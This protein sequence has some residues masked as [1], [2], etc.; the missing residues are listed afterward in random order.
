MVKWSRKKN[1]ALQ[2]KFVGLFFRK[3]NDINVSKSLSTSLVDAKVV[4][5]NASTLE[6]EWP[7]VQRN[8]VIEDITSVQVIYYIYHMMAG[9]LLHSNRSD[10]MP[11]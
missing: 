6:Y 9:V 3:S 4:L 2:A 11:F 1:Y 7:G 5:R 8:V 10:D